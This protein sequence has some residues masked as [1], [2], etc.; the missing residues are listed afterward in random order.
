MRRPT[1]IHFEEV[2]VR[3]GSLDK[4]IEVVAGRQDLL[5]LWIVAIDS[6]EKISQ[7]FS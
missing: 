7:V 4:Q 3:A 6:F 2:F 1:S 5:C